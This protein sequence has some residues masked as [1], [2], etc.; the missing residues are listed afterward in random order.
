MDEHQVDVI[1]APS[2]SPISGVSAAAGKK[3]L[4][5]FYTHFHSDYPIA[6]IPLGMIEN[7]NVPFGISIILTAFAEDKLL[8]FISAF[9]ATFP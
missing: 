9:E 7:Y 2:H 5:I 1:V 3:G 8:R 6:T 4:I